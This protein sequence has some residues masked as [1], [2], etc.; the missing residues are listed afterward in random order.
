M[1]AFKDSK[2][3]LLWAANC[4]M[5]LCCREV[6]SSRLGCCCSVSAK[7]ESIVRLP[8]VKNMVPMLELRI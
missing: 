5:V 6:V 3:V 8:D 2:V 1:A 4:E 7:D